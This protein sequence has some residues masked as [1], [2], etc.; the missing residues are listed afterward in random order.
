MI[1]NPWKP[2]ASWAAGAFQG[3]ELGP[4][5][6]ERQ[7]PENAGDRG[8]AMSAAIALPASFRPQARE[9]SSPGYS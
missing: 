4:T 3:G 5:L 9:V 1:F 7:E 6:G 2:A 8:W